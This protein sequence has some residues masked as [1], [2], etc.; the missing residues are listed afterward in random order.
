[1]KHGFES[2]SDVFAFRDNRFSRIDPRLKLGGTIVAMLAVLLS[3]SIILPSGSFMI[4]TGMMLWLKIPC[5][6]VLAKFA[7]PL[8]M[9]GMIGLLK[10][11]LS[12]ENVLFAIQIGTWQLTAAREGAA[13]GILIASR[14]LGAVSLMLLFSMVT[15]M[16]KILLALR[17]ARVPQT[18]VETAMLMY[19]Y[20][21]VLIDQTENVFS[22]QRMRLGYLGMRRSLASLGALAGRVIERSLNQASRTHQAM[23]T[24]GYNGTIPVG[25]LPP[26]ASRDVLAFTFFFITV[27]FAFLWLEGYLL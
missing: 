13:E 9:A 1:M 6:L 8:L 22:S 2:F 21:F 17:W 12:G 16:H 23:S 25:K 10:T 7:F 18:W 24:R 20:I 3:D 26:L 4:C 11:F 5:R 15:P 19:R 14:V 27:T